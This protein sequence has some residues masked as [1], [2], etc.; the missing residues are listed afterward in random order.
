MRSSLPRIS[1]ASYG[2]D[3]AQAAVDP[4]RGPAAR[5]SSAMSEMPAS[6]GPGARYGTL[7]V[8][9]LVPLRLML[10]GICSV[11][12]LWP[13]MPGQAAAAGKLSARVEGRHPDGF[14]PT[15]S[16]GPIQCGSPVNAARLG[17]GA[18]H[19]LHKGKGRHVFPK[20]DGANDPSDDGTSDDPNDDDDA[21]DDLNGDVDRGVP[22]L[23]ELQEMAPCLSA[24]KCAL[25]TRT[26]HPTS[27]FLSQQR[28]RC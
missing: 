22:V 15:A 8:L 18:I 25:V 7:A 6:S 9:C 13:L 24:P 3:H 19:P 12:L 17:S 27:P 21:W 28:L 5:V 2:G 23:A 10:L 26:T 11:A 16:T 20:I 14:V 1:E 4:E